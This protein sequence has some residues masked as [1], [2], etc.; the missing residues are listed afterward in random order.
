MYTNIKRKTNGNKRTDHRNYALS[1]A[2]KMDHITVEHTVTRKISFTTNCATHY[3]LNE[4]TQKAW[5]NITC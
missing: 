1:S 4:K 2:E 3:F 5:L